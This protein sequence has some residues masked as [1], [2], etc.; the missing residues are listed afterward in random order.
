MSC[1][2]ISIVTGSRA[3]FGLLSW[4]IRE[5]QK[6]PSEFEVQILATGSHY[7]SKHGETYKEILADGFKITDK[8]VLPLVGDDALSVAQAM[9]VAVG[10]FAPVYE[11]HKP[12]LVIVLGDRYEILGAS[13]AAMIEGIPVAHFCGGDVT[14]GAFDEAIRHS[15]S[16]IAS[17]HF[18]TN[19]DSKRRVEQ[20]GEN[21]DRVFNVGSLSLDA[22]RNL[23]LAT[24]SEL[25]ENLGCEFGKK[26]IL[27]TFHPETKNQNPMAD[28]DVVL[29]ALES[30]NTKATLFLTGSNADTYGQRFNE[31]LLNF[32]QSG[33]NRY[34]YNSL[35]QH[36][37]LSL[38]NACDVVFGNSSSGVY[39]APALK[40]WTINIGD[41]QKGRLFPI[42]I[43]SCANK[44]EAIIKSTLEALDSS[45]PEF[46]NP[47]GDGYAAE[48]SV[49]VLR[50]VGEYKNLLKKSF[51]DLAVR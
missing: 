3:E 42:S 17:L 5:L 51:H 28:L 15:I 7:S 50:E 8:V 36:R 14:E 37:Y 27:V 11:K 26:N 35:G 43:K 40:K 23:K 32:S 1:S 41:R 12:D 44:K 29:A 18:V 45:V 46:I 20:L 33:P 13:L 38:M 25:Q 48:L 16:K 24:K 34:F 2:K 22:L 39:E 10:G 21:P 47:Y 9:G 6:F 49:K 31:K 19:P 30:L 4:V